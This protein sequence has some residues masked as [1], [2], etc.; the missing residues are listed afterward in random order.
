ML[1]FLPDFLRPGLAE[2]EERRFTKYL[3]RNLDVVDL[4]AG[5]GETGAKAASR[6]LHG[7]RYVGLEMQHELVAVAEARV[8]RS[9]PS[10]VA[11]RV[12]HGAICSTRATVG[13][14]RPAHW[15]GCATMEGTEAPTYT[16]TSLLEVVG[17]RG[18]YSLLMDIEGAETDVF[19][20]DGKALER[21]RV[22]IL[23]LHGGPPNIINPWSM[24]TA[25][26]LA[27]VLALGFH[28]VARGRGEVYALAR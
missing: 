3:P 7:Q 20:N 17:M 9:A 12:L 14:W 1:G 13:V 4:G 18:D 25:D 26:T 28:L 27:R 22:M 24:P 11:V 5:R 2:R 10:G 8:R 16:L 15:S 6:L 21:C 19:A 23:E